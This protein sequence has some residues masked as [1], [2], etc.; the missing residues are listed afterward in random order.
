MIVSDSWLRELVDS[1]LSSQ[2]IADVLTL[3]GLEVDAVEAMGASLD[4]VIVGQVVAKEKHP[5]ADRLNLTQVDIGAGEN[6]A[7]VCGASNVEVGM[8][9]PVATIGCKLPIGLKIKKSKIRGQQ[10]FGMLCSEQE[11][12]LADSADG[13]LKLSDEA[14]I[15]QPIQECLGLDDTLIDIDLTP[16]RGDCLSLSGIARELHVLTGDPYSPLLVDD[17]A[18]TTSATVSVAVEAEEACPKYLGRVVTGVDSKATTPAWMTTRLKKSGINTVSVIVDITNYVMMELGQPMHAF[19]Q[20]KL[21][22][23][24]VVRLA[25]QGEKI[26]L[27]NGDSAELNAGSLI[28]ADHAGP[29]AIAGVMG[30]SDSAIDDQTSD[31]VLE[32]AHFTKRGVAGTARSYGLH[33][34]SSHRFERGVDPLLPEKAM[35]RA[36]QLV[37]EICG[38]EAGEIVTAGNMQHAEKAPVAVRFERVKRVLGMPLEA[39]EV[40]AMLIRIAEKVEK[41]DDGWLI[42]PPSYR[43]DIERE[44]DLVEEVARIKGYD[45]LDD[46]IPKLIPS[47]RVDEEAKLD[48][49]KLMNTFVSL[50]Y[51]EAINYSFISEEIRQDFLDEKNAAEQEPIRLANPLAENM[52]V[53]RNSLWPGL[54]TACQFNLNRQHERVRLFEIGTV[55]SFDQEIVEK[56]RIAGLVCGQLLPQQWHSGQ[57]KTVD[58]YDVRADLAAIFSLTGNEL[59]FIVTK[60]DCVALHPGQSADIFK[61]E[62]KLGSMGKIHPNLAKKYDLPADVYLF[63]L[64]LELLRSGSIPA[65]QSVSKFPSVSRDLALITPKQISSGEVIAEIKALKSQDLTDIA[66]FDVYSGKGVDEDKKSL[67]IKLTFQHV[68]RTLKDDEVE[69]QTAVVLKHLNDKF[70]IELR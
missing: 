62:V 31:I 13:L 53:M 61:G 8:K 33:T 19:D 42:T 34:D 51:Q 9:V 7:I 38:G 11:L 54:V 21:K 6:L 40:E 41:T 66:L 18:G 57:S 50:G 48:K 25:N 14:V 24:I 56:E 63:E 17:Q 68:E 20:A 64:D 69:Q 43:F 65:F 52:A 29:I 16:N 39:A 67:A 26:N 37:L 12:G 36:T 32:A 44:C 46:C 23:G 15:G 70:G 45:N 3:A 4:G 27:L 28:I 30:G 55:F 10:S 2:E 5:D 22:D 58:F 60:S 47:G 49:R 59:D 1:K 35:Q